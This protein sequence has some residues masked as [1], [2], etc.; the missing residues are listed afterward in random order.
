VQVYA[1][2]A[3]AKY[4]K[5]YNY[6]AIIA[7]DTILLLWSMAHLIVFALF[8][9]PECQVRDL[10]RFCEEIPAPNRGEK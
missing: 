9:D 5:L 4:H 8:I 2:V 10:S 7:L 6:W 3:E 1:V